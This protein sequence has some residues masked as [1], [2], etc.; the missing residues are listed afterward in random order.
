M[1][2]IQG[3]S[4]SYDGVKFACKDI[5][6]TIEAG[7]L[8]GFIGHNGAGKTTAAQSHR[9]ASTAST[10]GRSASAAA[11]FRSTRSGPS[12]SLA[13][14]PDNPGHLRK[15]EGIAVPRLRRRRCSGLRFRGRR[16]KPGSGRFAT[17][18]ELEKALGQ[19]I[20]DVLARD[21]EA[22]AWS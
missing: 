12:G 6:L 21:A 10:P 1:I 7:D 2:E 4:K 5:D 19:P 15:P 13:Y 17:M 9:R 3:F 22:E 20:S 11:R 8:Y 16:A 18:F 14:I